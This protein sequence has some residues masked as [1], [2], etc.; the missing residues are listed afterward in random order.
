[1]VDARA[2][3]EYE[4]L[5]TGWMHWLRVTLLWRLGRCREVPRRAVK[6]LR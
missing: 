4:W 5:R 6:R 1:M 3:D 2:V